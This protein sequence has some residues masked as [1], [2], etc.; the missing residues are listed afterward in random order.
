M[1]F[2][3]EDR[4]PFLCDKPT[5]DALRSYLGGVEDH[6]PLLWCFGLTITHAGGTSDASSL[7]VA[8]IPDVQRT[9]K[10]PCGRKGESVF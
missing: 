3:T 10:S 5:S 8:A 1:V 2:S 6:T 7:Q 4:R 9:S